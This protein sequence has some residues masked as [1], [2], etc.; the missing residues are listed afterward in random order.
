MTENPP[1]KVGKHNGVGPE[2]P[3][4]RGSPTEAFPPALGQAL[5]TAGVNLSDPNV[6]KTLEISLSM[7]MASGSLP[8]P[9]PSLLVEYERLYPGFT[10]KLIEWTEEQRRHR[11]ELEK[12]VTQ[13]S[14]IRMNRGQYVAAGIAFFGLLLSAIVGILGN[15]W[16]GSVLAIVSIGGPTAAIYLARGTGVR[17]SKTPSPPP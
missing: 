16:V 11:M 4:P 3:P 6:S 13:G 1:A 9:P 7:M 8:L 12:Q 17:S 5:K 14:E 10:A 15:S 2:T